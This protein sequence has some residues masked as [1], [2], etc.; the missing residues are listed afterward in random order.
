MKYKLKDINFNNTEYKYNAS[1]SL[2]KD[3]KLINFNYNND[4]LEFQTPKVLIDDIVVTNSGNHYLIL[5]ILP[6]EACRTFYSKVSD[7]EEHPNVELNKHRHWFSTNDK[8]KIKSIF[9]NDSFTVKVPFK[10]S[11]PVHKI[12]SDGNLFNYYHLK[13]GMEVI[14]L[15]SCGNIWINYDDTVSYNLNIKEIMVTK[16]T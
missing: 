4:C 5:K 9:E 3:C 1:L 16:V 10:Y 14:C 12:Y 6:T 11:K 13:K 7:L 8:V 15:L 2:V